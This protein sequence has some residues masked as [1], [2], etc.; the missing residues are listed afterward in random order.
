MIGIEG[1]EKDLNKKTAL[2]FH[3]EQWF[4]PTHTAL[5]WGVWGVWA[6]VY[7][8]TLQRVNQWQKLRELETRGEPT[9]KRCFVWLDFKDD[10][11]ILTDIACAM[12]TWWPG[13]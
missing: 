12:W 8:C 2:L 5:Q 10:E 11:C 7:V 1:R 9:I 6:H 4:P 13:S 3:Q